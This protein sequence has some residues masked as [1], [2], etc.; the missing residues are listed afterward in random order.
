MPCGPD[1]VEHLGDPVREPGCGRLPRP[2]RV[3][4]RFA[5]F[6]VP[7]GVDAEV[8][9]PGRRGRVDEGEEPLGGRLT[10]QRVHV[11]VEDDRQPAVVVVPAPDRAPVGGQLGHGPVEPVVADRDGHRHRGERLARGQLGVPVVLGVGRPEQRQVEVA[12]RPVG[13]GVLPTRVAGALPGGDV[14]AAVLADL[15][16][17]GS[18]MLDLPQPAPAATAA[19]HGPHRQ[20]A[21]RRPGPR[22]GPAEP[23]PRIA[24]VRGPVEV[25]QHRAQR[26]PLPAALGQPLVGRPQHVKI[27]GPRAARHRGTRS[28]TPP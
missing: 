14:P 7:A 18:V 19:D 22:A 24:A 27:L 6:G 26:A 17:P 1:P 3:P 8:L 11:V 15:P 21:A 4:P 28:P 2:D 13:G 5:Q 16:V 9:R 10:H 12:P 25:G 23:A 20:V